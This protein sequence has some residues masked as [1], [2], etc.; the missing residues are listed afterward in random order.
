MNRAEIRDRNPKLEH[1]CMVG[2]NVDWIS[3]G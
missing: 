1:A 3:D 2:R